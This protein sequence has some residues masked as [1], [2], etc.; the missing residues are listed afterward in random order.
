MIR[1]ISIYI[2]I[3]GEMI[4]SSDFLLFWNFHIFFFH[5]GLVVSYQAKVVL[6]WTHVTSMENFLKF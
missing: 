5:H 1:F 2:R 3:G 4:M 6:D